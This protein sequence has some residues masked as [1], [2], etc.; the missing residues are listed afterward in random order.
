MR[1]AVGFEIDMAE[2]AGVRWGA[3]MMSIRFLGAPVAWRASGA[4]A[5]AGVR[6]GGR[7][8]FLDVESRLACV[9]GGGAGWVVVVPT[10]SGWG[11]GRSSLFFFYLGTVLFF[12]SAQVFGPRYFFDLSVWSEVSSSLLARCF[13]LG[14]DG[15]RGEGA[16]TA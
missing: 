12:S 10:D 11:L 5:S 16:R 7:G 2:V 14:P 13:P 3:I 6:E 1:S 15:E 8:V 4:G 9:A